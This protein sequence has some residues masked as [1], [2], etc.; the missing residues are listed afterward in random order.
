MKSDLSPVQKASSAVVPGT[1]S[2]TPVCAPARLRTGVFTVLALLLACG[3]SKEQAADDSTAAGEQVSTNKQ[4]PLPFA[5]N[6][7]ESAETREQKETRHLARSLFAAKDY[8]KLEALAKKYRDSQECDAKGIWKLNAV[9][10]GLELSKQASDE[11]WKAHLDD[12]RAWVKARPASIT[13]RVALADELVSY[14]WRA[15]GGDWAYKVTDDGWKSFGENLQEAEKVL[16]EARTLQER[17]P[18]WWSVKLQA[19]MGQGMERARYDALF[20]EAVRS[21]PGYTV[22]YN[23]RADFLL[24]RWHGERGEWEADL[25]QSADQLGG[26]DGDLLYARVVWHMHD[27]GKFGNVI[28]QTRVSWERVDRGFAVMEKRYPDSL[29]AKS[30]R[31]YLAGLAGNRAM[32]RS[33]FDKLQGKVDL[34]VWKT[35]DR[36]ER[37]AAWVYGP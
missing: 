2:S 30:E 32:A 28:Q 21:Q 7:A 37:L 9:Y 33:Y 20:Q 18:R 1:A 15:R 10:V 6:I 25:A 27:F 11:E 22:F 13:A 19:A 29:A 5:I 12:Y 31:A 3:C 17:C 23:R 36:F 24:P 26:E 4:N 34:S 16:A 35:Q 14:G 8:D